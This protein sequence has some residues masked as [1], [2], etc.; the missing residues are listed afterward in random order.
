M[1]GIRVSLIVVMAGLLLLTVLAVGYS[2]LTLGKLRDTTTRLAA[3]SLPN[4]LRA[5]Q[6]ADDL[7]GLGE[8]LKAAR[9]PATGKE[10]QQRMAD[11]HG[12]IDR[13][14]AEVDK[15]ATVGQLHVTDDPGA[16]HVHIA[17]ELDALTQALD[18]FDQILVKR[19][20]VTE[21]REALRQQIREA[22]AAY[23]LAVD[24]ANRQMRALVAR[25][26]AIDLPAARSEGHL[27]QRLD[28]FQDR[29]MSWLGTT[30]D[31]RTDGREFNSIAE[32]AMAASEPAALKALAAQSSTVLLRMSLYKRLP[33]SPVVRTLAIRTAEFTRFFTGDPR[34][35]PLAT[36]QEEL[37]LERG[38]IVAFAKMQE[39]HEDLRRNSGR[40]VA[41]LGAGTGRAVQHTNRIVDLANRCLLGFSLIA[42]LIALASIRYVITAKI[43]RI[44]GLTASMLQAASEAEDGQQS[45]LDSRMRA[46][47]RGS[48][49]D[50]IAAMG[51]ALLALIEVV[52]QQ[53]RARALADRTAQEMLRESEQRL[54]QIINLVPHFIFAKD[55]DGHYILVNQALA[56]AYGTTVEAL[57]GKKDADFAASAEE[58]EHFRADDLAVIRSGQP[59]LIAE[60]PITDAAGRVRLLR[61]MKIPFTFSGTSSPAVLGV[62]E[63][64]TE[65]KR[66]EA[67]RTRLE[68][69][70]RHQQKLEAIGALASGVAHEINNPITGIMNYAQL[71]A[72]TTAPGSQ[73]AGYAGEII[74]ETERVAT[75]V[76]NLLQFARQEKQAHSPARIQDLTEQ[77]LSLL[78]AVFRRDQIAL[79]VDVPADLPTLKCRSQQIQQVLMNLL[80]N[81]RDAL[82]EKYPGYHADKTIRVSVRLF[83]QDDRR[84]LRMTVADR[85]AGIPAEI[86]DRIFDPFFTT[87]PRDQGTGLGLSISHGIV[88]DHHGALHFETAPGTGTQFHLDLPVDNGWTVEGEKEQEAEGRGA[89]GRGSARGKRE[90]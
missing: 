28:A 23:V 65:R 4:L 66:L 45:S 44:E 37:D 48:G 53:D 52:A 78:R 76:R 60:E 67:E 85:G 15:L 83:E 43:K 47:V 42:A 33:D 57:T 35:T 63:N 61:T 34:R 18:R 13:L 75:I 73:A 89:G 86:R 7:V 40:L 2:I 31:L 12:W 70:V 90:T 49:R 29:E 26:L 3:E 51:E 74:G 25:T 62:C 82:N 50:E 58:A 39:I 77:T 69:Q 6:I 41:A 56:D 11:T 38:S 27:E 17:R 36:R 21:N 88:K 5:Q 46:I 80:T 14:R 64:I 55:I 84:W 16:I 19:I 30:Q 68:A 9:S 81:A 22:Y 1:F 71:I 87:K 20:T 72:D 24:D 54:R 10:R 32:A 79:A 59:K 8:S